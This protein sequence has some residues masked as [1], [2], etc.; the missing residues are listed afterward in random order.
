[1]TRLAK[2]TVVISILL[3]FCTDLYADVKINM[4]IERSMYTGAGKHNGENIKGP[5]PSRLPAQISLPADIS[6]SESN[7]SILMMGQANCQLEYTIYTCD[8]MPWLN[9]YCGCFENTPDMIDISSLPTDKYVLC[10]WY[11]GYVFCGWF[12]KE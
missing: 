6:L 4:S 12:E 5:K 11:N 1:M 9:G 10:I 7:N 8:G 3:A 2:F